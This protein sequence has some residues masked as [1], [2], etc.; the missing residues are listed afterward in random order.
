MGCFEDIFED[1]LIL[2][3]FVF[4]LVF[5]DF[6]EELKLVF[7]VFVCFFVVILHVFCCLI[8]EFF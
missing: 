4:G 6:T 2:L 7:C 3:C 8:D 1:D 5:C